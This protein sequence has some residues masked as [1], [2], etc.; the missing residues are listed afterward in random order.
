MKLSFTFLLSFLFSFLASAQYT[1]CTNAPIGSANLAVSINTSTANANISVM[2]GENLNSRDFTI[3]FTDTK[4]DADVAISDNSS[5]SDL[6]IV[7][8]RLSDADL[9]VKY[10]EKLMNPSVRIEVIENGTVDFLVYNESESFDAE[11]LILS[12]LPIINAYLGYSFEAIP[13]W[14]PEGGPEVEEEQAAQVIEPTYYTGINIAH[15]IAS[16]KDGIIQLDDNSVFAVY[17]DD[18]YISNLWQNKNDVVVTPTEVM[19]HYYI[20]KDGGIYKEAETLR[21]IC[22]KGI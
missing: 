8:S 18:R 12:L 13:Y 22:I 6:I 7:K 19:G 5:E 15:W 9:S 1:V 4:S 11:S 20:T 17:D 16:I 2:I 3:G 10:G 14:G 21:A